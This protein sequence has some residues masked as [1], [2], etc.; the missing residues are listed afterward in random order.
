MSWYEDELTVLEGHSVATAT[1]FARKIR[2]KAGSLGM[3][4]TANESRILKWKDKYRGKR[5]FLIGN[6]PSLNHLDL[7][8]LGTEI[9]FGVNAIYLN[10]EKM[11]FLPTHYI[12]EDTFVAEDRAEEVISLEGPTKWFG[13]Y[14]RYCLGNANAN[15]LTLS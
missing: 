15:W 12:V 14:L 8:L 10:A 3:P 5:A 4:L 9:T 13:N 7:S 2:Y 11:G 6:G 1:K